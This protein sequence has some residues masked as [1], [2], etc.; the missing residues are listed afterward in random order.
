MESH[1]HKALKWLAVEWLYL[2]KD[3]KYIAQ[4]L[5]FGRYIFDVVGSDGRK[6]YIIEAK[7]DKSDFLR[8]CNSFDEIKESI[9]NYKKLL[10]DT[11]DVEKYTKLIEVERDKSWKF[12]DESIHHYSSER[13]VICPDG[14]IKEEEVPYGWGLIN[15]E[16][17]SIVKSS[18][19][20]VE[21]IK[22]D[23][24]IKEIC[25]KNT[26]DLLRQYGVSFGKQIEFPTVILE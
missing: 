17:R 14:M 2:I 15:E 13:Y 19:S 11:G 22:V 7:Q 5:S 18:I 3:C 8:E 10:K 12:N 20:D 23:K 25:G 26:R 9:N 16:P 6:V 1:N 24:I 21:Q 4:E